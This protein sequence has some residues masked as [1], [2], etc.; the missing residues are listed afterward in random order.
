MSI[1][2]GDWVMMVG[3]HECLL[4]AAGGIPFKVTGFTDVRCGGWHCHRCNRYSAGPDEDAAD[5]L[6]RFHIPISWLIKIDPPAV[7]ESAE[8]SR[9]LVTVQRG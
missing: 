5:G 3:G 6:P 1:Q 2:K 8:H 7:A 4:A 9:E